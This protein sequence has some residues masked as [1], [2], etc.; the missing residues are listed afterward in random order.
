MALRFLVL[1]LVMTVDIILILQGHMCSCNS[2]FLVLSV[3]M[4]LVYIKYIFL[5][6]IEAVLYMQRFIVLFP[7]SNRN[8]SRQV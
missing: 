1:E 5:V 2:L 3:E 6:I 7:H 4:Y 8:A